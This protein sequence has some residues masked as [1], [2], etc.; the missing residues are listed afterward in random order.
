LAQLRR[1]REGKKLKSFSPRQ[2]KKWPER[3][4]RMKKKRLSLLLIGKW[5]PW[6]KSLKVE[7]LKKK[8]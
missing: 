7:R 4:R 8:L 3:S 6:W 5:Q 1:K 2:G